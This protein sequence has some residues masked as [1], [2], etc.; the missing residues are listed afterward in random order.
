[1]NWAGIIMP[2]EFRGTDP[3]QI[4]ICARA[5]LRKHQVRLWFHD[6]SDV[7]ASEKFDIN[8]DWK[9]LVRIILPVL[10]AIPVGLGYD[11]TVKGTNNVYRTIG[12][13]SDAGTNSMVCRGS[14]IWKVQ[15]IVDG[16][17]SGSVYTLKDIWLGDD[18]IPEHEILNKIWK[19]QPGYAQ[20]FLTPL[21]YCFVP[22][23]PDNPQIPDSTHK[24]L[25]REIYLELTGRILST[26]TRLSSTRWTHS[27]VLKGQRTRSALEDG[28]GDPDNIPNLLN[29]FG[30]HSKHA[31]QHYRI[32]FKEVGIPVHG[33]R[34]STEVFT[35]IQGGWEGLHAMHLSGYV[36]RDVSS[37]NILLV[38]AS[39]GFDTR[40]VIM[41]LEYAKEIEDTSAPHDE[42]TD[43]LQPYTMEWM[44]KSPGIERLLPRAPE[45]G[46]TAS[47]SIQPT[48]RHGIGL[49]AMLVDDLL[50]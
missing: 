8:K 22:L 30:G 26:H 21:D 5:D 4:D 25:G 9:C 16:L 38:P 14:R 17:P 2:V 29:K 19:E 48:A 24:T 44:K 27:E 23:D 34:K 50:P 12:I 43:R 32:V 18:R 39:S 49:V 42:T 1:M 20:Y 10:S 3:Y 36:H 41:D 45:A 47:F 37:R 33:L 28:V 11:P 35:A 46:A 7:V 40:G 15:K 31:R 13:L 6:R